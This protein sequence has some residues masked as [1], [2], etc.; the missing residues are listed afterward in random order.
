M[1]RDSFVSGLLSSKLISIL[2]PECDEK[3]F[4]QCVE[5]AKILQQVKTDVEDIHPS[6]RIHALSRSSSRV[7]SPANNSR[8]SSRVHAQD[9]NSS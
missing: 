3:S 2:I 7:H 9:N 8:S 1:L 4:E 6:S 5:R